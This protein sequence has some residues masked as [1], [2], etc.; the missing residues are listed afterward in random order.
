MSSLGAARAGR[1]RMTDDVEAAATAFLKR[2]AAEDEI[3]AKLKRALRWKLLGA[4]LI[5]SIGVGASI[6]SCV[7][8][9]FHY[10]QARALEGIELQLEGI[11]ASCL[12]TGP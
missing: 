1:T 12:R 2:T 4:V 8:Q 11:R 6:T 5:A 7:G 9:S 10:R 3:S